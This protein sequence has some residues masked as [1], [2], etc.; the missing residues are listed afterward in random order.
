[1]QTDASAL[2]L[3]RPPRRPLAPRDWWVLVAPAVFLA[4][5]WADELRYHRRRAP[6]RENVIH[7][8]EHI[9]EGVMWT[10]LYA[11]R[12]PRWRRA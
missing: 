4:L 5:G 3:A 7:A 10:A 8:T 1:M 12:L 2:V 11:S 6:H 9:A